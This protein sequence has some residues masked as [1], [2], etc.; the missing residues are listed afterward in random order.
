MI[1]Y[2]ENL[3]GVDTG[4]LSNTDFGIMISFVLAAIMIFC[5]FRAVFMW[6][7]KIFGR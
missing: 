5:G 4:F 7:E 2:L 3:L 1:E 6:F